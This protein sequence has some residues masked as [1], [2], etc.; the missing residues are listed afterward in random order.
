MAD[1]F[2]LEHYLGRTD[3]RIVNG[4]IYLC[5]PHKAKFALVY[6]FVDGL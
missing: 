3:V 4:S 6:R 2:V 5:N 1:S